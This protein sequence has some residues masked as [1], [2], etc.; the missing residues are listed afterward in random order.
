MAYPL[1]RS[2]AVVLVVVCAITFATPARAEAEVLTAIAIASL[3]VVGVILVVYLIIAN[4][5]GDRS[6]A[7]ERAVWVACAGETCRPLPAP[8]VLLPVQTTE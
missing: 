4:V 6:A 5:A 7:A 2:V 1:L 8:P 3:V